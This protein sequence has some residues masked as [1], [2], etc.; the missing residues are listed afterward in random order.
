M[1]GRPSAIADDWLGVLAACTVVSVLIALT[2]SLRNTGGHDILRSNLVESLGS[3]VFKRGGVSTPELRLGA[4]KRKRMREFR[5]I[6]S[7]GYTC[8]HY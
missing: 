1:R 5:E 2:S 7:I 6:E 4:G 8:E 3:L